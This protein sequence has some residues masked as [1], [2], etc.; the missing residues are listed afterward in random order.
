VHIDASRTRTGVSATMMSAIID[1]QR[2][3]DK[4]LRAKKAE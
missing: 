4:A 1:A 3:I 2:K